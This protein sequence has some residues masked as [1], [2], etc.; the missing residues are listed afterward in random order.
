MMKRF[1]FAL[2]V[3]V[4]VF[5]ALPAA[6]EV[7]T[8]TLTNGT[9]FDTRYQPKKASWDPSLIVVQADSG[10]TIA[11]L[12]S[13]IAD[14]T[15]LSETKGFGTVIDNTTLD[16]GIMPNDRPTED[17]LQAGSGRQETALDRVLDRNYDQQQFV[18]PGNSGG[19]IPVFGV[20]GG[21]TGLIG[22]EPPSARGGSR[23]GGGN[24]GES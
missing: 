4:F 16:L 22:S 20:G 10:N 15:S 17:E 3:L 21:G 2:A 19:G 12:A 14:V 18:E 7:F 11:L 1:L 5:A 23:R 9:S 6:G 24:R 13:E 8:V